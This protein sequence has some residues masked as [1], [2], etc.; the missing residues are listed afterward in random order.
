MGWAIS[1]NRAHV[2]G[3]KKALGLWLGFVGFGLIAGAALGPRPD[4]IAFMVMLPL[5]FIAAY[6]AYC[7]GLAI[8]KALLWPVRDGHRTTPLNSRLAE[9]H[10]RIGNRSR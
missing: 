9:R 6:A 7:L 2:S 5:P 8:L 1:L 3:L 4:E 10:G